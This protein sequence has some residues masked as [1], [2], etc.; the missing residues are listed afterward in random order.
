[1]VRFKY[2]FKPEH[3]DPFETIHIQLEG[4]FYFSKLANRIRDYEESDVRRFISMD[5]GVQS[6]DPELF[7]YME[8]TNADLDIN[9]GAYTNIENGMGLFVLTRINELK[10][11][12]L[13]YR[14]LDSLI[15]GRFTKHLNFISY[16]PSN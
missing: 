14:A 15:S 12:P 13:D 4:D 9:L 16:E 7:H 5:F 3:S 11:Y 6:S 8:T 1:M 10:G 2:K